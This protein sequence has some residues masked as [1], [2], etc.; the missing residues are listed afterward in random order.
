MRIFVGGLSQEITEEDLKQ[1][2]VKFGQVDAVKIILDNY[3]GRSKGYGFIEM[4]DTDEAKTAIENLNKKEIKGTKIS[5]EAAKPRAQRRGHD[6][7]RRGGK[8][9]FGGGP[10]KFGGRSGGF[11]GDQRGHG[12]SRS[13]RGNR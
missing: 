10:G 11:H 4:P 1:E 5:V 2:F 7:E 3:S 12:G 9:G 13:S 6:D 8:K